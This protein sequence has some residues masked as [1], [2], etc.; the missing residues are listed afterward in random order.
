MIIGWWD[1]QTGCG[2]LFE[3]SA[4]TWYG[5]GT[6]GTKRMVAS[7]AHID[8]GAALG[9]TYGSYEN[10]TADC[11]ADFFFTRNGSTSR[12]NIGP[13]FVA[14][15]AWDDPTTT[16]N[17]TYTAAYTTNYTDYGWT[18]E[19]FCAEIDAGR[20]VH[21]G[22]TSSAGGHSVTAIGYNNTDGKREYICWTTWSGWGLRSWAWD[23][24][25]ESGYNFQV[26]GG[27][28]LVITPHSPPNNPPTVPTSVTIS[29]A[30][31]DTSSDLTALASGS[32]DP[33]GDTV[34]YEYQWARS[35]DGGSTWSAWGYDGAEL[36]GGSVAKGQCWKA[37]ARANDGEAAGAW[38]ESGIVSVD[39]APPTAPTTVGIRP[40]KPR[41]ASDLVA[42]ASG[43]TD[44]DGDPL[45]YR[46]TWARSTDGG[47]TWSGWDWAGT[48]LRSSNTK[49]GEHW[50]VR[51]RAYDGAVAGPWTEGATVIIGNTPPTAPTTVTISPSQ[52]RAD[53]DL[54]AAA[55]GATDVDG[56]SLT[57]RY[58]WYKSTNG[59]VTWQAGPLGRILAAS[60]TAAG[61][62]WRV[63]A[64]AHDG[65]VGGPWT[66]SAS[67]QIQPGG[68]GT[69]AMS[70][71]VAPTRSGAVTITVNL[72]TAA[73]VHATVLN[74]AGRAVAIVPAQALAG[75]IST[76]WW[77]GRATT[78]TRMPQGQY[79]LR[80]QA[81]SADGSCAQ[82][83]VSLRK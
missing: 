21:L 44:A 68:E 29:P 66:V 51:G 61:E 50:K 12:S 36:A 62:W 5:S 60:A 16:T 41:T 83:L 43:S 26:Y 59:G 30:T 71:A 39:N 34:V 75:G 18:Y 52:P 23:G 48:V 4:A 25:T 57:Y 77:D 33:D 9:L 11:I 65:T 13:G 45:T 31:P 10:H 32:S 3:D 20:P 70:A 53:Q 67:V 1:A 58:A 54:K 7:Q 73:D 27:T 76:L 2:D 17:E 24:E 38:L 63:Q 15:A 80:I 82:C 74:L 8:A 49:K 72:S 28:Y 42:S 14:F 64:R 22:L 37:R 81:R 56:D 78:G 79:L 69:L 46:Y 47:N 35:T 55:S 6:S 40:L 19:D